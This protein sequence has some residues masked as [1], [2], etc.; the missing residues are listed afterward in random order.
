[1]R[2]RVAGF[3]VSLVALG[4]FAG[5]GDDG[6]TLE[7]ADDPV[8]TTTAESTTTT[9]RDGSVAPLP[10]GALAVEMVSDIRF[11]AGPHVWML[12]LTNTSDQPV[13]VTFP[14]GQRGD[15]VLRRDDERIHRWSDGRFFAQQVSEETLEPGG[16][17]PIELEDD[18]SGV[19][20]GF[21]DA[22]VGVSIVDAPE[23]QVVS[24]RVQ[25]P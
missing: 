16:V 3:A 5:C 20:P 11:P 18:L 24:V 14:T 9:G 25:S 22:V 12:E 8:T 7:S 10:D 2:R 1:M 23:P 19:E 21:Y 17:L 6:D 4:V 13:T 15:V